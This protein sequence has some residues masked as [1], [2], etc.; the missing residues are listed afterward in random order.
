MLIRNAELDGQRVDVR[1]A[2]PAIAA[3]GRL[4]RLA[5][6]AVLEAGGGALLPGLA[7]HHLHLWALAASAA[8]VD[9]AAVG[10]P[11]A[12][13]ALLAAHAGRPSIRGI[14]YPDEW[15]DRAWLDAHAPPVPIRIQHRSGRLWTLNGAALAEAGLAGHPTGRLYDADLQLRPAGARRP[16][17]AG[18]GRRLASLG[19]TQLAEA[20]HDNG[21]DEYA[22]LA[23]EQASGALPQQVLLLGGA[24]L[25][26]LA[27]TPQLA[28]GPA[29]FHLH[30]DALP[31]F[32]GLVD[33]VR[34]RHAA[35]RAC[36][37]HCVG[38]ADLVFA[39][40]ALAAAGARPGDRIEHASLVAPAMLPELARLP[41]TVVTQ[42]GLVAA[43]G[44][45]YRAELP[46]DRHGWLYRAASLVG[47]GVPLAAGS[48]APYGPVD[49]W[50][51][52][53]AAVDRRTPSGALLGPTEALS[54]EQALGLLLGPLADPGGAPRRVAVGEAAD[55][56]LLD[57][58]W[59]AARTGLAA[60]Q[61]RATW[62]AGVLIYDESASI[63]PQ[64]SAVAADRRRPDSAI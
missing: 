64:D 12:L 14:N 43:R 63:S 40:A 55:L 19:L 37:F 13:A 28:V 33:A 50:R 15:I 53:Q 21:P 61:V 18:V 46:A 23:A 59:A 4:D 27:G 9:C 26:G 10:E 41:V 30:E 49:P 36:A 48:D 3:I 25:D 16:S 56:C 2:G 51:A 20:G 24:A 5:G 52:L 6:E 57:R 54:P 31:E 7:D 62:S 60:V 22:A 45:L 34:A 1:L 38:E 11:A 35:G 29:K 42:P 8:S 39:T 17:L 44:D 32:D 47:A 58:P